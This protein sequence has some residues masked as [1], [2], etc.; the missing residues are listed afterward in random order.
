VVFESRASSAKAK[1]ELEAWLLAYAGEPVGVVVRAAY[2]MQAVLNGNPFSKKP[3]NYTV[4]LFLDAQPP[5]DA[6]DHPVRQLGGEIRL[7]SR[8][9]YVH[10]GAGMGPS[11]LKIAT[12]KH[13]TARIMNS[14]AKLVGMA[15]KN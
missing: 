9:I 14:V 10:F 5:S 2:E 11:K 15:I 12:A 1:S 8:E 13:G 6:L 4:A 3:P 7:G